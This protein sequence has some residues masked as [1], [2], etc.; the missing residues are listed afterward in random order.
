M[1]ARTHVAHYPSQFPSSQDPRGG[2][3]P[4]TAPCPA[5]YPVQPG[6]VGVECPSHRQPCSQDLGSFSYKMRDLVKNHRPPQLRLRL[7]MMKAYHNLACPHDPLY[8]PSHAR[9][10]VGGHTSAPPCTLFPS[11]RC[12]SRSHRVSR[13]HPSTFK[14][15]PKALPPRHPRPRV[16]P[17]L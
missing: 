10:T 13:E 4:E 15:H 3:S 7:H 14:S 9:G 16:L 2:E 1:C 5:L 12:S 8:H 11:V 6:R 17:P